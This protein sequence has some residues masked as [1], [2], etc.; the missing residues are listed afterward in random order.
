MSVPA[1][2]KAPPVPNAR[3]HRYPLGSLTGDG[4]LKEDLDRLARAMGAWGQSAIDPFWQKSASDWESE[5]AC[6]AL[7]GQVLLGW[8]SGDA[9][10][11]DLAA[12]NINRIVSPPFK[13]PDGYIGFAKPGIRT[14]DYLG[15][16]ANQQIRA[17][18]LFAEANPARTDVRDAAR[19]YAMW[20]TGNWN[21]S[22]YADEANTYAGGEGIAGHGYVGLEV[23]E[24][25]LEVFRHYPHDRVLLDWAKDYQDWYNTTSSFGHTKVAHMLRPDYWPNIHAGAIGLTIRVPALLSCYDPSLA[26]YR[27]ATLNALQRIMDVSATPAGG[28]DD[29]GEML[30]PF[31]SPHG[32]M[33]YCNFQCY[34]EDLLIAGA[35]SGCATWFDHVEKMI[36]NAAKGATRKDWTAAAYMSRVNQYAAE[37][38]HDLYT[39]RHDPPCCTHSAV[40]SLPLF[41]S[42][43]MM[44]DRAG[45]VFLTAYGPCRLQ[46]DGTTLLTETT[47]YPFDKT[48]TLTF[49][50]PF[51]HAVGIRI[52][53]WCNDGAITVAI[54]GVPQ[55]IAKD[56]G[57]FAMVRKPGGFVPHDAI[58][59]VFHHMDA[60]DVRRHPQLPGHIW[61]ERGPL[62]FACDIPAAWNQSPAAPHYAYRLTPHAGTAAREQAYRI[63]HPDPA[64]KA[65]ARI[66]TN[67]PAA[68]PWEHPPLQIQIPV[69]SPADPPATQLIPLVPYGCTALR[70]TCFPTTAISGT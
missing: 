53:R 5:F 8:S 68:Y 28:I 37:A 43:M 46:T 59:I 41:V 56:A 14:H 23:V 51:A 11:Q 24:A 52:P 39:W 35:L 4:W 61:I 18:L 57:T 54:N 40:I 58:A 48:V 60:I 67:S 7:L 22:V 31:D 45:N 29:K 65:A 6:K 26:S 15:W 12:A 30:T 63:D 17:L 2:S 50:K 69:T 21:R 27:Q 34:Q 62:V 44:H 64:L 70:T 32:D 25:V 20:F 33:E 1:D 16:P 42:H 13:G 36:Y 3:L 49:A 47:D 10:I 38:H 55:D 19:D 66:L 9:A